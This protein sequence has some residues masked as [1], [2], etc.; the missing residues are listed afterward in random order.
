VGTSG[1]KLVVVAAA[2]VAGVLVLT[3]GFEGTTRA[4]APPSNGNGGTQ[5]ES[6]SPNPSGTTTTTTQPPRQCERQGVV[7]AIYNGTE[8]TG[9]A[10]QA[11]VALTAQGYV[12]PEEN[13]GNATTVFPTTVFYYR[14]AQ[15]QAEAECL[16]A[17]FW[18]D[19]DIQRL[20]PDSDVPRDAAVAVFLG[21]DYAAANP[22]E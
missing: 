15:G 17:D 6:P 22:I 19:G 9:L 5:T 10:A 21:N 12:I 20:D 1:L 16:R 7:L 2:V 18:P 3:Q 14:N 11:G 4:S 13:L 8:V